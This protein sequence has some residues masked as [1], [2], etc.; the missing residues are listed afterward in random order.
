[1]RISW[2]RVGFV[3]AIV[4]VI[5]VG[6]KTFADQPFKQSVV[7]CNPNQCRP[8]DTCPTASQ[9]P[10]LCC[11]TKDDGPCFAATFNCCCCTPES[12]GRWFYG[13]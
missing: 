9:V 7:K 12:K 8:E 4:A 2:K 13:E 11:E 6:A 10:K 1:M 3:L 5:V